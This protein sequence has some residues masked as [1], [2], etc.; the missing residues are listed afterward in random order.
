MMAND[1]SALAGNLIRAILKS[2]KLLR[3]YPANNSVY[4]NAIDE[5]YSSAADYLKNYGD[6]IFTIKPAEIIVDSEQVYH[7]TEKIDN[8]A[9]FF[10]R[11]GVRELTFREGLKK[12]ELEDFLKLMGTDFTKDDLLSATWERDFENIKLIVDDLV[13]FE[14]SD[15]ATG[16]QA[17]RS[18][19]G[20]GQ[21]G[22]GEAGK[23]VEAGI[24]E[25]EKGSEEEKLQKVYRE[26]LEKEDVMPISAGDLAVEERAYIVSEMQ[27]DPSEKTDKLINILLIMLF[28]EKSQESA[29]KIEKALEDMISYSL[30]SGSVSTLLMTLRSIRQ[31]ASKA[32]ESP[33]QIRQFDSFCI[34]QKMIKQLGHIL[35]TTRSIK[36]EDMLEY[37]K[38]FGKDSIGP[39]ITLLADLQTMT[40]RRMVNNVLINVGRGNINALVERLNDPVWYV[41]R[42]IIFVL[43]NIGDNSVQ[44]SILRIAGHENA[45]VR[46]EVLKALGDFKDSGSLP[47]LQAGFDDGDSL[48]R[49]TA[50]SVL[51]SL[52]ADVP[53]FAGFVRDA[54]V[55]KISGKSFEDREFREK[56]SFYEAL[57]V[58]RDRGVEESMLDIIKKK[59]FFGT[60]KQ[61]ETKACAAHYLGLAECRE[62][63]PILEKL[64]GSSDPL[65][66]EYAAA[67]GQRISHG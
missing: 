64:A 22:E 8:F 32:D 50:V 40:A 13:L 29:D 7:S 3:L 65:I 52:A 33:A 30:K 59:V 15:M 14:G 9:M 58:V 44:N 38:Y 47:V 2:K 28:S 42:N 37:A 18:G 20:T 55:E 63:L 60:K 61:A 54:I 24:I 62:A 6:I 26:G 46:L 56:K 36:E 11:E 17:V 25:A 1:R 66:A 67:A 39:L 19:S 16:E 48:V 49:L 35:D 41:V 51:G 5:V 45:R 43:R 4:L 57:A 23:G 53:Q 10:F 27:K 34:D 31:M 21:G 12:T